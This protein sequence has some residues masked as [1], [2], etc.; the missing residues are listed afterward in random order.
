MN[1][2]EL[3][4]ELGLA[5]TLTREHLGIEAGGRADLL[6]DGETYPITLHNI[7]ELAK[8]GVAFIIIEKE[9]IAKGLA[10]FAENYA[11]AIVNTRGIFVEAVKDLIEKVEHAFRDTDR[12]RRAW[13]SNG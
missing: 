9:G 7:E 5:F 4:K 12:L 8:K 11:V 10:P 6:Y 1:A 3:G 13:S 2:A